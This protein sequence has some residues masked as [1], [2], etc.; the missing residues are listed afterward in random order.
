[1]KSAILNVD[2]LETLQIFIN[3]RIDK[4]IVVIILSNKRTVLHTHTH[5]HTNVNLKYVEPSERDMMTY[6]TILFL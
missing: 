1:M 2:E 5:T 4:Q 6:C 3:R